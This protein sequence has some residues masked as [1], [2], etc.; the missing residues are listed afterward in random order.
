MEENDLDD[1]APGEAETR[2]AETA[3]NILIKTASRSTAVVGNRWMKDAACAKEGRNPDDWF[4]ERSRDAK[5]AE[6]SRIC[7]EECPV[8]LTCLRAACLNRQV[9]GIYGGVGGGTRKE[10]NHDYDVLSKITSRFR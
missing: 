6:A 7:F 2:Q 4:P 9:Y 5:A 1:L 10:K 8:R 3:I